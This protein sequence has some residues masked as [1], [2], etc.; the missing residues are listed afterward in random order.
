MSTPESLSFQHISRLDDNNIVIFPGFE[1]SI[2][3]KNA[4]PDNSDTELREI[5]QSLDKDGR[6]LRSLYESMIS[7]LITK[8][9]FVQ[10]KADYLTNIE[11]LS[12]R[13]DEIRNQRY[14]TSAHAT[15]YRDFADAVSTAICD[16]EL[17]AEIIERLVQEI[18]VRPDKSFDVVFRFRNEFGE[19]CK[20]G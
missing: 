13:A 1:V 14:E 11:R 3:R 17:T 6:M 10:M 12:N 16:D 19:V 8:D 18:R 2:E 9:E 5:N 20:V 4:A 15:E 7:G